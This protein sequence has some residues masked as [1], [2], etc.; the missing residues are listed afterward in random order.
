MNT[1]MMPD[2]ARDLARA[3]LRAVGVPPAE[4]AVTGDALVAAE[5]DGLASHGLSRLP[6]YLDQAM[7]G[8]VIAGAIPEIAVSGSVVHVDAHHGL[9]FPAIAYGL[10]RVVPLARELGMAAVAI[11]RSHHFGVA[12]H[13]VEALARQG[14][15]AMAFSNAP[16]AMA[17]WGGKTPLFGTNPIAFASPREQADPLVIDLSL[18]KV[19]RGKVM[20]AK[21]AGQPIPEGWALDDQGRATTD[22]DAAIAGSMVPAGDA[23]GASLALMVE[24]LTAGLTGSC[25]G[26]Q[27]SSFFEP[28]GRA[29]SVAHLILAFDPAGFH[30]GYPAHA[31][32]LF[33]AML[34]QE[35]VR[36]PGQRRYELRKRAEIDGLTLPRAL[37]ESLRGYAAGV[38]A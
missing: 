17:P 13:P 32:A 22:P 33:Q 9:A 4:A 24:L 29:P 34:A 2:E 14:L 37:V 31:E 15:L 7:S 28:E 23:K 8:K 26:F 10:E 18:S 19:A 5:C 12:G 20:L 3:A 35:G 16:S 30:D 11:R 21:K 38:S 6:F 36:L 1:V 25:F 27:A